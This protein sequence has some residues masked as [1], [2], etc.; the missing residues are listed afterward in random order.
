MKLKKKEATLIKG[1]P[2]SLKLES[3]IAIPLISHLIILF[4]LLALSHVIA[5]L[6]RSRK[7]FVNYRDSNLTKVLQKDL[8]SHCKLAVICCIT[9]SGMY[10]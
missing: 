10:T 3:F 7:G 1:E 2:G 9:P 8:K 6:A 4:S 5:D